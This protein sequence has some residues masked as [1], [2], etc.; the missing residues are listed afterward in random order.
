MDNRARTAKRDN[1]LKGK[2]QSKSG[3]VEGSEGQASAAHLG[4][5]SGGSQDKDE[6][7]NNSS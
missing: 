5:G 1:W 4:S 7:N 6:K 2:K 3:S